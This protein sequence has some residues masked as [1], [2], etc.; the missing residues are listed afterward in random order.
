MFVSLPLR[1]LELNP[2]WRLA[3]VSFPVINNDRIYHQLE[4]LTNLE[5]IT[6]RN[7]TKARK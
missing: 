1:Q 6:E 7:I 3:T 2:S 4:L 5:T